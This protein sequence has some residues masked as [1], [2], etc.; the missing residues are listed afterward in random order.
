M[1]LESGPEKDGWN[2]AS[3]VYGRADYRGAHDRPPVA[4]APQY[5]NLAACRRPMAL[6]YSAISTGCDGPASGRSSIAI[7][8]TAVQAIMIVAAANT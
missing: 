1:E 3:Q 6:P 5:R 2:E 7:M 8:Q 4:F